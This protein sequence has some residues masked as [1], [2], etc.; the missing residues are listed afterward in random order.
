MDKHNP[1]HRVHDPAQTYQAKA[2]LACHNSRDL[3]HLHERL[4]STF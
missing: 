3:A 2:G 4:L 1:L